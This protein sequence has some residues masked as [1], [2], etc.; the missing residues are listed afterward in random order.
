MGQDVHPFA[1]I[2]CFPI[3]DLISLLIATVLVLIEFA[4]NWSDLSDDNPQR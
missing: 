2:F 4:S 3:I 1:V